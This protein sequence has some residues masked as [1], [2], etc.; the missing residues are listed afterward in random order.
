M[1]SDNNL[2]HRRA[3]PH[4]AEF[5]YINN[6]LRQMFLRPESRVINRDWEDNASGLPQGEHRRSER[7]DVNFNAQA[8]RGRR[9]SKAVLAARLITGNVERIQCDLRHS[10]VVV[11]MFE[12]TD[13]RQFPK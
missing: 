7:R 8:R 13:Q 2:I 9:L 10:N 3:K 5:G 12:K 11:L 4:V 6:V 1:S